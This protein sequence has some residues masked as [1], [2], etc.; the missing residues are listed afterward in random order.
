MEEG[1]IKMILLNLPLCAASN[2]E[3]ISHLEM[4]YETH[5]LTDTDPFNEY[6]NKLNLLGKKINTFIKAVERSHQS[7]K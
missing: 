5:S 7:E 3:T 6:Q 2:I 4:L 1:N